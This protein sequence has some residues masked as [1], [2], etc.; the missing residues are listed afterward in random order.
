MYLQC[1]G[2]IYVGLN[3]GAHK[4]KDIACRSWEYVHTWIEFLKM[5][6]GQIE[7]YKQCY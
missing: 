7:S 2:F 1:Y 5:F 4:Y 6:L 3:T